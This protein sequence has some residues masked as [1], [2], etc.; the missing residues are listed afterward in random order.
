MIPLVSLLASPLLAS[1]LL[2]SSL[3][4]SRFLASRRAALL[5]AAVI[6]GSTGHPFGELERVAARPLVPLRLVH[7]GLLVAVALTAVIVRHA[8]STAPRDLVGMT[9][10]ALLT[11]AVLS[12]QLSWTVPLGY[13]VICIGASSLGKP[14]LLVWPLLPVAHQGATVLAAV[15]LGLGA[16]A[17]CVRR[18]PI[19]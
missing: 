10:L 6:A 4:T 12:A 14:N 2:A 9:G 16:L 19:D 3:L 17:S 5:P 15:L 18:A 11:A 7:M 8:G 13:A 1:P